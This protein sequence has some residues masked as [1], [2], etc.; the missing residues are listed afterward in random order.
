MKFYEKHVY[1]N[2]EKSDEVRVLTAH[3]M[4]ERL[5]QVMF[6]RQAGEN[7]RLSTECDENYDTAKYIVRCE[8]SDREIIH[9]YIIKEVV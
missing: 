9:H 1:V 5:A 4:V 6:L 7:I 2:G 3:E 8:A